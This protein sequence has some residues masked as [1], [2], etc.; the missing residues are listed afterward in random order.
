MIALLFMAHVALVAAICGQTELGA[1]SKI[2]VSAAAVLIRL[3]GFLE[4]WHANGGL[5]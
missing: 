3:L 4:G 2:I 5:L 1:K